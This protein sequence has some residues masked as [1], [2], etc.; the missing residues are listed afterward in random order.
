MSST[1]M[2]YLVVMTAPLAAAWL[3]TR[4]LHVGPSVT[5]RQ[6]GTGLVGLDTREAF[7]SARWRH[8]RAEL[9]AV[10]TGRRRALHLPAL[11][12]ATA[13]RV[14]RP[15]G[16]CLVPLGRI[17][18]SVDAGR[19]PFDRRFDPTDDAA[20]ARFSSVFVARS[21]GV[22]LPPVLLYRAAHGYYVLDGHHR[23]AVAR[24]LG[25]REVWADVTLLDG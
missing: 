22:E 17:I 10:L 16:E 2:T 23:V 25:D 4:V 11:P 5:R 12:L 7:D 6:G 24:A 8:T 9:A 18:G 19:H 15:L 20:W 14:L 13:G 3:A 21:E 1:M